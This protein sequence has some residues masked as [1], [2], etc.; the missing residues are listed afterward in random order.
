MQNSS[1][2]IS[3]DL[4]KDLV[5]THPASQRD[6][7]KLMVYD[8]ATDTVTHTRFDAILDFMKPEDHVVLNDAKVSP[9]RLYWKGPGGKKEE[10]VFLSHLCSTSSSST[11]EVIV[12]GKKLQNETAYHLSDTVIFKILQRDE[13]LTRICVNQNIE[14]LE[15]FFSKNGCLP[16]PPYILKARS[17]SDLEAVAFNDADDY[18]T[19]YAKNTGAVAAPTAGLHFTQAL[20]DEIAQQGISKHH[21]FLKVGWGTFAP[22]SE[23]NFLSQSLHQEK[24]DINQGTAESLRKAKDKAERVIAVGTTVVRALESWGMQ[25]C[26]TKAMQ[27]NTNLFIYPPFRFKVVDALV[28]NFHLPGSSLLF[29]VAAF[30]GNKGEEKILKLYEE[31]VRKSYRF[32]SYGD[33][34]LII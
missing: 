12:S 29:L 24:I 17:R 33:A 22:V 2:H 27:D 9:R 23:K 11:W 20:L 30:L 31:A 21:V 7:C 15:A 19:V 6:H 16:I 8:R 10:V 4:P 32:Y 34:M 1:C 3:F 26:P 14:D 18:Q 13:K 28:T 5:A 25:G